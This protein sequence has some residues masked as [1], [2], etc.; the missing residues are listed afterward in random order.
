[1][2]KELGWICLHRSLLEWEWYSDIS[3]TRLWIHCLLKASHKDLIYKNIEVPRGSFCTTLPKLQSETKISARTLRTCLAKLI[4]TGN[5]ENKATNKYRLISIVNFEK[6]QFLEQ[7]KPKRQQ[8][9]DRQTTDKL[10]GNRQTNQ[11]ANNQQIKGQYEDSQQATDRQTDRQLTDKL[12]GNRQTAIYIDKQQDKQ[13]RSIEKE[14]IK[15]KETILG[16]LIPIEDMVNSWNDL[17]QK[18]LAPKSRG[19]ILSTP[20]RQK[21]TAR[22]NNELHKNYQN[23]LAYLQ[24]IVTTPFLMGDNNQGWAVSFDWAINP[25]NFAKVMEGRYGRT[26]KKE[27]TREEKIQQMQANLQEEITCKLLNS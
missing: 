7:N 18:T 8:A 23:W 9:T 15:E 11:Q 13:I 26:L 2:Q 25:S 24:Q 19:V 20:R 27:L 1:M 22:W 5:I 17:I 21:L 14:I 10:T 16:S 12:T 6:F 3:T 4:L